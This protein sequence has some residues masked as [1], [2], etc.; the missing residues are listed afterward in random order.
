MALL[1]ESVEE[2]HPTCDGAGASSSAVA[3]GSSTVSQPVTANELLVTAVVLEWRT[4][5]TTGVTVLREVQQL[6]V[7][8]HPNHPN[9]QAS[10]VGR[11]DQL[12]Q[13]APAKGSTRGCDSQGEGS[14]CSST[15]LSMGPD[16]ILAATATAIATAASAVAITNAGGQQ[17][18]VTSPRQSQQLLMCVTREGALL[19]AGSRGRSSSTDLPPGSTAVQSDDTTSERH[20]QQLHASSAPVRA[21][22]AEPHGA[23]VHM[24]STH[25]CFG[26]VPVGASDVPGSR[27]QL[28][29]GEKLSVSTG[30]KRDTHH[31]SLPVLPLH[32]GAVQSA[33]FSPDGRSLLLV[34]ADAWALLAL[35][36][37]S[38]GSSDASASPRSSQQGNSS[39]QADGSPYFSV[40]AGAC[41]HHSLLTPLSHSPGSFSGLLSRNSMSQQQPHHPV[42]EGHS[43]KGGVLLHAPHAGAGV[44][45]PGQPGSTSRAAKHYELLMWDS[46]GLA[47]RV[48]VSEDG[49]HE[50]VPSP[51][52]LT[53][54]P[55]SLT[56]PA[57]HH[58]SSSG[59]S[60]T[61]SHMPTL[62]Q[63]LA[64]PTI[65]NRTSVFGSSNAGTSLVVAW[66]STATIS[67]PSR[68]SPAS[69]PIYSSDHC[70]STQSLGSPPLGACDMYV[71]WVS[72]PADENMASHPGT[73]GSH[74]SCDGTGQTQPQAVPPHSPWS[75]SSSV[76]M[77][78]VDWGHWWSCW[79]GPAS[80]AAALYC[81]GR[82]TSVTPVTASSSGRSA[83]AAAAAARL[84]SGAEASSSGRSCHSGAGA[85]TAAAGKRG[86]AFGSKGSGLAG[87][88]G[89]EGGVGVLCD[90]LLHAR[91]RLRHL[92]HSSLLPWL[93]KE[94]DEEVVTA[95]H[96]FQAGAGQDLYATLGDEAVQG[97]PAVQMVT[98]VQSEDRE[99]ARAVWGGGGTYIYVYCLS[100]A[101][102]SLFAVLEWFSL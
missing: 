97:A 65:T 79:Q 35:C 80:G 15:S 42:T 39:S 75:S 24:G 23:T 17:A 61:S 56:Q 41:V 53:L 73:L 76:P 86:R 91:K 46:Q 96:T 59:N 72:M 99:Q 74:F 89:R 63:L 28:A 25:E 88:S 40:L 19:A 83:E 1:M 82:G 14:R 38:S 92:R 67:P 43:W 31:T 5:R 51:T 26:Q 12:R 50:V 27:G 6:A 68:T 45:P 77:V 95:G 47:T 90:G 66:T 20:S 8:P 37:S 10:W 9:H 55:R 34:T 87:G 81:Q 69:S 18:A 13:G 48:R 98:L 7:Q 2:F 93:D 84:S 71:A 54:A 3:G 85:V 78:S 36:H 30:M 33:S 49:T 52:P 102:Y 21:L 4:L 29:S 64:V 94:D 44:P 60:S 11:L 70:Q 101:P 100:C 22:A 16:L 57:N 62:P 58:D 32:A